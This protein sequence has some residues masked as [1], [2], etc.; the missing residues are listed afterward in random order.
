MKHKVMRI[1]TFVLAVFGALTTIAGGIGLLTGMIQTPREWLQG[2]PFV[3]YTIPGLALAVIVGGSML[4]AAAT[5]L[6]RREIGVLASAFTGLTMIIFEI[7]EIAVVDRIAGSSLLIAASLQAFYLALGLAV[8][9]LAS[10]LW[11][12][13]Y[14]SHHFTD[15]LVSHA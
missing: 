3:D 10:A 1:T 6:T 14:R 7:V 12:S 9:G 8:V 5:I 15:R 13:E 4:F 2:S 11:M